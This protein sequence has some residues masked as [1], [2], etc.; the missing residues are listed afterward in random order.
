[1]PG[2]YTSRATAKFF[3]MPRTGTA[4][5]PVDS[6]AAGVTVTKGFDLVADLIGGLPELEDQ[7][8]GAMVATS[9]QA[10][11]RVCGHRRP[12]S[13]IVRRGVEGQPSPAFG[14]RR[15]RSR[16]GVLSQHHR[17]PPG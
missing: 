15:S 11:G 9:G 10:P 3:I 13:A 14:D 2:T 1:M 12:R 6:T 7:I 5:A 4:L 16:D 17:C 8:G